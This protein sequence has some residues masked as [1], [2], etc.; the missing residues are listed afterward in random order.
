MSQLDAIELR[1]KF[2]QQSSRND[3]SYPDSRGDLSPHAD[4]DTRTSAIRTY[5]SGAASTLFDIKPWQLT[6]AI[7]HRAAGAT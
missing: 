1:S 5:I 4:R 2:H 6:L 3:I 7:P